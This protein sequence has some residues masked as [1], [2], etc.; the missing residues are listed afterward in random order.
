MAFLEG[1]EKMEE[2]LE[3]L[4]QLLEQLWPEVRR[5][6][7]FPEIPKPR[8]DSNHSAVAMEMRNKQIILNP[9]YVRRMS[10]TLP[11]NA[12][13]EALLDHGISHYTCCPWDLSTHLRFY[14]RA[15]EILDGWRGPMDNRCNG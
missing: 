4:Q 9:Q 15:K 10:R 14:A 7:L 8:F 2:Q 1:Q 13:L 5:R 3:E 12:V 6:H 11:T